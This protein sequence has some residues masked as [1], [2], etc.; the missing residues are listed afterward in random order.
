MRDQVGGNG[1][2]SVSHKIEQVQSQLLNDESIREKVA[3]RAYELYQQRGGERGHDFDDWTQAENEVLTSLLEQVLQAAEQTSAR[4]IRSAAPEQTLHSV[5]PDQPVQRMLS[6]Q[7]TKTG[8]S[9][10][11]L[12]RKAT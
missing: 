11:R 4:R 2:A 1:A 9:F 12:N 8:S 10:K 3:L 6:V 5:N 7:A